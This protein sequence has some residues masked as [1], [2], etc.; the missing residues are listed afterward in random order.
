MG[1]S[2]HH[3]LQRPHSVEAGEPAAAGEQAP[4]RPAGLQTAPGAELGGRLP[5]GT[6]SPCST[7]HRHSGHGVLRQRRHPAIVSSS[8][9]VAGGCATCA[10][11][12]NATQ[13]LA[14]TLRRALDTKHAKSICAKLDTVSGVT[15]SDV[16]L[17]RLLQKYEYM[18]LDKLIKFVFLLV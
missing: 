5:V 17:H 14:I 1:A 16:S 7:S 11:A 2:Q 15:T 4:V 6:S 12:R 13:L 10:R 18:C 9:L 3:L 8:S